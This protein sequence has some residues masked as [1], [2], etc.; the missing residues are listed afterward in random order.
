MHISPSAHVDKLNSMLHFNIFQRDSLPGLTH[1]TL[2][3][4]NIIW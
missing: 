4:F 1:S 2:L 3:F